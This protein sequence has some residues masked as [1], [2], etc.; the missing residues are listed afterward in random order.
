MSQDTTRQSD[1]SDLEYFSDPVA[2]A[3]EWEGRRTDW[4][5]QRLVRMVNNRSHRMNMSITLSTSG[6]P[7][8]GFLINVEEYFELFAKQFNDG[9]GALGS[10]EVEDAF[11]GL[12][13]GA[14]SDDDERLSAPPQFLHLKDVSCL[15]GVWVH[16]PGVLWRGKVSDVS[17]FTLRPLKPD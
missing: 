15:N 10:S 11:I 2:M 9:L 7:V 8:S 4:F 14:P 1:N 12:G 3:L 5:L 16:E 13:K 6:G 17:G